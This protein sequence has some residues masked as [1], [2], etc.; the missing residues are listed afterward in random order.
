MRMSFRVM[1]PIPRPTIN[2]AITTSTITRT[3][4][5]NEALELTN[6]QLA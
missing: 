1:N 3:G 4:Y 5:I 6:S 2:T